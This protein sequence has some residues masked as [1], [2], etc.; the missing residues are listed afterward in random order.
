VEEQALGRDD[1]AQVRL[2]GAP[3]AHAAH[4]DAPRAIRLHQRDQRVRGRHRAHVARPR[5]RHAQRPAAPALKRA[6]RHREPVGARLL[7]PPAPRRGAG[8]HL[9][10]GLILQ[11]D[12]DQEHHVDHA[13]AH[14]ARAHV[15]RGHRR[16]LRPRRA[17]GQFEQKPSGAALCDDEI[18]AIPVCSTESAGRW[19][20]RD[21]Q[22]GE[23]AGRREDPDSFSYLPASSP[24]CASLRSL[25]PGSQVEGQ[26][27]CSSG[28]QP[29]RQPGSQPRP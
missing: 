18:P 13:R 14:P 8:V 26:A 5:D 21:A 2:A 11:G 6:E 3:R 9:E 28:H 7:L 22:G 24:P 25:R 27:G 16:S 15:A 17:G 4:R 23:E 19:E 12:R 1:V 29:A 10:G 20:E